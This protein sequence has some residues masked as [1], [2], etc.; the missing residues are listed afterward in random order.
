MFPFLQGL[1]VLD[2]SQYV[3]GPYASL[4]LRDLGADVVKVEPPAGDPMRGLG[5]SGYAALNDGK[6]VLR[7]DL[8]STSGGEALARLLT[9][10]DVLVEAYRPGVLDRLGFPPDRLA[11]LAPRLIRVTLTGWGAT[12]PYRARAGH[13]LTYMALGGGLAGSGSGAEPDFAWPPVSDYA[14]GMQAAMAVLAALAGRGRGRGPDGPVDLDV[15]MMESVLAW[16]AWPLSRALDRSDGPADAG[17]AA[18][19]RSDLLTGGAACY[20][21][22]RTGDGRHV[23]LAA[24]EAKFWAAFCT[25]M[26]RPDWIGRK[27]E[28]MPQTALIA[29]VARRFAA[30]PLDHWIDVFDGVDCCFEPVWTPA[31]VVAHPQ[32]VARGLLSREAEGIKIALPM[33]VG[34]R[35]AAP[36]PPVREVAADAAVAAWSGDGPSAE[37]ASAAPGNGQSDTGRPDTG[38]PG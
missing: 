4:I 28:P 17:G 1:R 18:A 22:Y 23:A 32:V 5:E 10:A 9:Y 27:D 12:G 34:G 36:R 8:K 13:D 30:Q 16:Q 11:A 6:S 3:P 33:L 20:R 15:S 24:L 37:I 38:R 2:L 14:A 7:L 19:R 21:L 35:A 25:A 29:A 26:A 31:E